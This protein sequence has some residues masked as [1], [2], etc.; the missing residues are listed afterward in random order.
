MLTMR[1]VVLGVLLSG[2]VGCGGGAASGEGAA[3]IPAQYQG[4]I[5]SEDV[6]KGQELFTAMCAD[7]HDGSLGPS[8]A[9]IGWAAGAVRRQIREGEE[10]MPPI[11]ANRLSDE[12]ME[13][14]LAYM[15]STGGVTE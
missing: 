8:L 6:A 1:R 5:R 11:P 2:V 7:C 12:D 13:H 14:V 15:K 9:G 10:Q 3:E 4:P